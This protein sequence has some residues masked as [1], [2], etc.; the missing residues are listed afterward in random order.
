M[1]LFNHRL[2]SESISDEIYPLGRLVELTRIPG[3]NAGMGKNLEN[4]VGQVITARLKEMK[5]TQRWLAEETG[6]SN[7]AVHN[8]IQTGK[9]ARENAVVVA[10]ALGI[11]TDELF[12]QE[13][14]AG[15]RATEEFALEWLN[16]IER[17]IL[18]DYRRSTPMGQK[19][20]ETQAQHSPKDDSI[21][22]AK[23]NVA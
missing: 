7:T 15:G 3:N 14:A 12:G 16:P 11:S 21:I 9:I 2:T 20:I 23:R 8:W 17:Q 6:V 1:E 19:M 10:L 18:Q 4:P 5:K 13:S 22:P